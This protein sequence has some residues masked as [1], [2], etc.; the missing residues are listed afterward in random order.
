[1][2]KIYLQYKTKKI[3]G[4][5]SILLG[6]IIVIKVIPLELIFF[7]LGAILI[8]IGVYILKWIWK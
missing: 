2:K 1:M 5:L 3:L 7:L 8:C 4:G 6:I